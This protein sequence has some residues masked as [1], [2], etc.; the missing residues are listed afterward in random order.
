[1]GDTSLSH[2]QRGRT[3]QLKVL[4]SSA[5]VAAKEGR[6]TVPVVASRLCPRRPEDRRGEEEALGGRGES[7]RLKAVGSSAWWAQLSHARGPVWPEPPS[8]QGEGQA[9]SC[10]VQVWG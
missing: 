3:G 9:A 5:A 6:C 10:V 8:G 7:R 1:M 4:V 2:R